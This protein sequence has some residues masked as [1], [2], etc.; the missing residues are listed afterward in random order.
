MTPIF[1]LS[2]LCKLEGFK[3]KFKEMHWITSNKNEHVLCDEINQAI[4]EFQDSFAEEGLAIYSAFA[5]NTFLPILV[6]KTTVIDTLLLLTRFLDVV[7]G[8]ILPG[9]INEAGFLALIDEFIGKVTKFQ[10]L[11]TLE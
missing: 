4:N 9:S 5:P 10:Y 1:F 3:I 11:S 2:V 6:E 8:Q 7:R